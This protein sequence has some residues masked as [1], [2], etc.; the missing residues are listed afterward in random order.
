M[1][2]SEEIT[3]GSG[4]TRKI[5]KDD[6][7]WLVYRHTSPSGKVYIGI[8]S[9][10]DPKERWGAGGHLYKHNSLFWNAIQ[11]YGWD[12]IEHEILCENMEEEDAKEMEIALIAQYKSEGISYNITDGGDGVSWTMSQEHKD[13]IS[14]AL[15][16][17]KKTPEHAK[18]AREALKSKNYHYVWMNKDGVEERVHTEEIDEYVNKGWSQGRIWNPSEEAR[19]KIS[20]AFTGRTLTQEHKDKV[21]ASVTGKKKG[22]VNMNDGEFNYCIPA[23]KVQECLDRG[24]ERGYMKVGIKMVW[25]HKGD[26]ELKIKWCDVDKYPGWT[27]GRRSANYKKERRERMK[28]LQEALA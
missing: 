22:Y 25:I 14:A 26:E 19:E 7:K 5:K 10:E 6:L 4:P 15:K 24:W 13:K 11:K 1:N 17:K 21:K 2:D 8:T 20:K 3:R 16:G 28:R 9:K 18:N 12:N 27:K 23:D